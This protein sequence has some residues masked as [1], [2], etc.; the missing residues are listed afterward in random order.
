MS[1]APGAGFE[2][3]SA[4]MDSEALYQLSYPGTVSEMYRLVHALRKM[5][6]TDSV[7]NGQASGVS[8]ADWAS[9]REYT[10][11]RPGDVSRQEAGVGR[12]AKSVPFEQDAV[13]RSPAR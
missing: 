10:Q 4:L 11:S 13:T 5:A 7:A 8:A 9:A 1:W 3:A 12:M 2:P 6:R